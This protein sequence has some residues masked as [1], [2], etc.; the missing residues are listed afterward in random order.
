MSRQRPVVLLFLVAS[1]VLCG[2][3][4]AHA[5]VWR[6]GSWNGTPGQFKSIQSAVNAAHPGDWILVGP[7]DYHEQ[8]VSGARER[9]GVRVRTPWLHLRGMDRNTVIVDG[10]K[11][12]AAPCSGRAE[13][14]QTTDKGRNGIDVL[15]A[16]GVYVQN[17]TA[18]NF[19]TNKD[20]AEGNE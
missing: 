20:G 18:C 2:V 6:V 9:A 8:G 14:Q 17:L 13:D 12:G 16:A 10:T 7:G 1:L 4:S 15:K 3:Q 19:L 5:N 11:P